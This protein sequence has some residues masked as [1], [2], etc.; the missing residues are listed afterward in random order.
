V[1]YLMRTSRHCVI[2]PA[3]NAEATLAGLV[4]AVKALSL[5]IVV[6]DDGSSDHTAQV[7]SQAGAVVISHLHNLGKGAALRAGFRHA[8]RV[9][10][11][12]VVTMD[13]DGQHDPTDVPRLIRTAEET[14]AGMVIGN[15]MSNG[16]QMPWLRRWTNRVMSSVVSWLI[17]QPVPDS[18]CGLR[19]IRADALA[20]LPLAANHFELETELLLAA[21]R[22]RW[23]VASL[24]IATIYNNHHRSYIQP[25]QDGARF[26]KLVLRYTLF[27]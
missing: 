27:S 23:T 3:L 20:A 5:D 17:R 21:A 2:I 13:G 18:Q 7:A 19:F 4:Q 6:V 12:G 16:H 15:R 14:H 9:G 8:L 1:D 24:P 11:A 26:M 22:Q 25:L 10:Y